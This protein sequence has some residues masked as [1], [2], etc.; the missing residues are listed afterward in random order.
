M[1]ALNEWVNY[2]R[3][4]INFAKT[5]IMFIRSYQSMKSSID[6]KQL[7]FNGEVIE[8][9]KSFK[10]LGIMLDETFSFQQLVND[11]KRKVNHNVITL[12]YAV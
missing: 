12:L 4:F 10:L 3:L 1:C 7:E 6:M 2:N 9:V 5:K 11:V 8:I